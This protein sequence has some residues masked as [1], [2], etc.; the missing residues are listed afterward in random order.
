[1]GPFPLC[2]DICSSPVLL[3]LSS[4]PLHFVI[5]FCIVG[6]PHPSP[7]FFPSASPLQGFLCMN[8]ANTGG[9]KRTALALL[10]LL[11]PSRFCRLGLSYLRP[12]AT[13]G[14]CLR[15]RKRYEDPFL[16]FPFLLPMQISWGAQ[17]LTSVGSHTLAGAAGEST[18]EQHIISY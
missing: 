4:P 8:L 2:A 3:P 13:C 11:S 6:L 5:A 17:S 14:F 1:M 10:L 15:R 12:H 7:C 16:F 18:L 9:T